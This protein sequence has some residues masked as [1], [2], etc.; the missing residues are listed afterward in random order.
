MQDVEEKCVHHCW[1]PSGVAVHGLVRVATSTG[2]LPSCQTTQLYPEADLAITT[3]G[4]RTGS[5]AVTVVSH[6]YHQM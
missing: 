5:Y 3:A 6:G 4:P 1:R 2:R